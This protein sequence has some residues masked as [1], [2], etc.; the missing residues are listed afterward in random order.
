MPN[1]KRKICSRKWNAIIA[2]FGLSKLALGS[3]FLLLFVILVGITKRTIMSIKASKI[4]RIP[5]I[6]RGRFTPTKQSPPPLYLELSA[7][8]TSSNKDEDII[9]MQSE[10]FLSKNFE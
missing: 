9:A 4:M 6:K 8:E 2:L 7:P 5:E 3:F 10:Q 1:A